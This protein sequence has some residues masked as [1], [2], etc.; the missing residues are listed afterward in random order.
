[1]VQGVFCFVTGSAKKECNVT[2][3]FDE[4]I[5]VKIQTRDGSI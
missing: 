5:Y 4:H 3:S 1:M 2:N